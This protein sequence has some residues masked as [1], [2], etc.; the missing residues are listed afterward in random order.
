[1]GKKFKPDIRD[2]FE[3]IPSK[4][5]EQQIKII[6]ASITSFAKNGLEGTTYTHLAK[7]CKIS[8][9]LIH[10]YFPTLEDLFLL[11]AK[12]VRQNLL[13]LALE[14][15]GRKRSDNPLAQLQGYVHGCMRWVDEFPHQCS[16]WFLY[17]Y[18]AS[19]SP[20]ARREN[21]ELVTSGHKRITGLF[22]KGNEQGLWD[23]KDCVATAK[24]FQISLTGAMVS[25][26]SEDGYL[27][28]TRASQLLESFLLSLKSTVLPIL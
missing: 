6:E 12:Y 10:H 24:L 17:F 11:T 15:M 13:K 27:T 5:Q 3:A 4:S 28:T 14:E 7:V 25:C 9:P 18:Q 21:S 22:E 20:L 19:R 8:R 1:M 16:F 2:L 23:V 26:M